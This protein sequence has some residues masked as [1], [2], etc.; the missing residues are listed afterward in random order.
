MANV[1]TLF[2]TAYL[3]L[4]CNAL[5]FLWSQPNNRQEWHEHLYNLI[6]KTMKIMYGESKGFKN[7][8]KTLVEQPKIA[9]VT[10]HPEIETKCE[11]LCKAYAGLF[12]LIRDGQLSD[13]EKIKEILEAIG[14]E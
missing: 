12:F 4:L 13:Q 6:Y 5:V 3:A 7:Y 8:L 10:E 2:E 9:C 1:D 11:D 14:A